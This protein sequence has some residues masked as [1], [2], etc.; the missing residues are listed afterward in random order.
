MSKKVGTRCRRPSYE[1]LLERMQ[2]TVH[3]TRRTPHGAWRLVQAIPAWLVK[4]RRAPSRH[5]R[6]GR[7]YG[8]TTT[9]MQKS[10]TPLAPLPPSPPKLLSTLRTPC[11]PSPRN[12]FINFYTIS[13]PGTLSPPPPTKLQY[14]YIS[15]LKPLP[16]RARAPKCWR[17]L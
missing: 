17:C 16:P 10:S 15:S 2:F 12:K 11:P 9:A 4:T 7:V 6:D 3:A 14:V 8:H 1:R 5:S 13:T